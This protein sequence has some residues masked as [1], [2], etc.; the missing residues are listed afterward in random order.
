MALF[1]L[2]HVALSLLTM[3]QIKALIRSALQACGFFDQGDLLWNKMANSGGQY[4]VHC[5]LIHS[6]SLLSFCFALGSSVLSQ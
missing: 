6:I 2:S 3:L 1:S 5:V 4:M